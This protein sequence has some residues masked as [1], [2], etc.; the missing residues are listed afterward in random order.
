MNYKS[1][2]KNIVKIFAALMTMA[3][4]S[5]MFGGAIAFADEYEQADMFEHNWPTFDQIGG[6]SYLVAYVD[7]GE[8]IMEWDSDKPSYP[9]SMTKIMTCLT[10]LE[11]PDYDPDRPV[12]FSE[13]AIWLPAAESARGNFEIGET[14]TTLACLYSMMVGSCND[15]ARALAE[16]YGGS[17]EAF[18]AMMNA[19]AA[20]MGC[21]NTH[22]VDAAGFGLTDHFV[23]ARDLLTITRQALTHEL[24]REMITTTDFTVPPT[25]KHP[26][27]GWSNVK[28]TN[29]LLHTYDKGYRSDYIKTITGVKTGTTDLAGRC[30]TATAELYDGREIIGIMFNGKL[31]KDGYEQDFQISPLMRTLLEEAAKKIDA[32]TRAEA[33][34]LPEPVATEPQEDTDEPTDKAQDTTEAVTR[35]A[36]AEASDNTPELD[37]DQV[38]V[39]KYMLFGIIGVFVLLA[40]IIIVL[41]LRNAAKDKK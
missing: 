21:E 23:S 10:V 28:N 24:F 32:P 29:L 19:K 37:D 22:F 20:E 34:D 26:Y 25:S 31:I 36:P 11:S 1:A 33:L 38:V 6:G 2:E 30:L 8:I 40:V 13:Y 12:T 39:N 3:L 35:P 18:C 15:C 5:V 9:A 7:S 4:L 14:T 16:T 17:E 41:I 27:S